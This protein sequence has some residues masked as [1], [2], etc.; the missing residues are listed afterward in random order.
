MQLVLIMEENQ[1]KMKKNLHGKG[2]S[3]KLPS[4]LHLALGLFHKHGGYRHLA[5]YIFCSTLSQLF[6]CHCALLSCSSSTVIALTKSKFIAVNSFAAV[7]Y[8]NVFIIEEHQTRLS[9]RN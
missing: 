9:S 3:L 2:M 4:Q 8:K 1:S 7:T 6:L 5:F